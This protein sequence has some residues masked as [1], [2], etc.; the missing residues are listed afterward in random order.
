VSGPLAGMVD[1]AS[2]ARRRTADDDQPPYVPATPDGGLV[3]IYLTN[4]IRTSQGP[5]P[6]AKTLPRLEAARLVGARFAVYGA[7]PPASYLGEPAPAVR[8]FR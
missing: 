3:Q 2:T 6:G 5:G 1:G 4:A 8:E 7:E